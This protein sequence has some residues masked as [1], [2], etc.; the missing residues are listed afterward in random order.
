MGG[1]VPAWSGGPGQ[2]LITTGGQQALDLI[3]KS[4]AAPACC[5]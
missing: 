5:G 3:A 2:V 4:T 1:R